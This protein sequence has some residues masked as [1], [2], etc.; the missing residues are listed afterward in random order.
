MSLSGNTDPEQQL[1]LVP[2]SYQGAVIQ[3]RLNDGYIN[4]TAMCKAAGRLF[5]HYNENDRTE[6]FKAALSRSIGIP[7]DQLVQTISTGGNDLRG[8][9][10]HPQMAIHLAQWLSAEFAVLVSE[11]VFEW[12]SGRSP[13]DKVWQQF[14]DRVSL[15]YDNVPQGYF[16]IFRE[17]ADIFAALFSRGVNPGTR[18]VLDISVGLAWG[19]HWRDHKLATLYGDRVTFP[20]YY[21]NYFAQAQSN[22]QNAWCYPDEAWPAFRRWMHEIYIPTKLPT[23]LQSQVQQNKITAQSANNTLVALNDRERRRALPK[24]A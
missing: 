3:Q 23:Y 6:E 1:A 4:A 13:T 22:P 19:T 5:G 18:M 2:H 16:C 14:E 10:V 24:K 20:H 8:S 7:I 9:W 12:L 17:I 11:W 21:P 15:V